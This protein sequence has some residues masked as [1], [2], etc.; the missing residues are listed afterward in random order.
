MGS[1]WV[2]LKMGLEVCSKQKEVGPS[3][4]CLSAAS[5]HLES[6]EH[7]GNSRAFSAQLCPALSAVSITLLS[8]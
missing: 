8:G 1:H 3:E 4:A 6:L 7:S 5:Q 2:I